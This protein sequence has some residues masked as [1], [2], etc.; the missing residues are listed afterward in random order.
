MF[1]RAASVGLTDDPR[2]PRQRCRKQGPRKWG[3]GNSPSHR[4]MACQI[5][6]QLRPVVFFV[7]YQSAHARRPPALL[8]RSYCHIRNLYFPLSQFSYL[9]LPYF[10]FL[11][12]KQVSNVH[13]FVCL[14]VLY[15]LHGFLSLHIP[16]PRETHVIQTT[17]GQPKS[18]FVC[19]FVC[20]FVSSF[21]D[22]FG[23]FAPLRLCQCIRMA[24]RNVIYILHY[25]NYNILYSDTYGYIN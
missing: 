3:P 6:Y 13:F 9:S 15:I 16:T 25:N 8:I 24:V 23:P 1:S 12:Y 14:Y 19:V 17:D 11:V 2:E 21:V 7:L 10:Y 5:P 18:L 22:C 4:A 20:L